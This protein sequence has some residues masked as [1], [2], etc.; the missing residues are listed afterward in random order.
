[1]PST[2]TVVKMADSG[3][4][5]LRQAITDANASNDP[6][7][8]IVFAIPGPGVHTI[9]PLSPLP[10]ITNSVTI[11][12]T[13]QPGYSGTPLIELDGTSAGANATGLVLDASNCTVRGLVINSFSRFGIDLHTSSNVI[14]GN[15]VGVDTTG[16]TLRAD[17]AGVVVQAA[18]NTIGG[19]SAGAGNVI[20]DGLDPS[21][22][23]AT[24]IQGNTIGLGADGTTVLGNHAYGIYVFQSRDVVIGGDTPAAR[25]VISGNSSFGIITDGGANGLVIQGNYIGTDR[26]GT[27]ARPNTYVGVATYSADVLIGGLTAT[28]GTGPGNVISGNGPGPNSGGGI[29]FSGNAP[30]TGDFVE[31]NIIGLGA[32]GTTALN[33]FQSGGVSSGMP[34]VTIGGTAA[35][36]R[37]VISG[38]GTGVGIVT[39]GNT[40]DVVEGNYIGTDVSGTQVAANQYGVV[41]AGGASG[42]TIGGATA[43]AGNL[44]SGNGVVG[45]QISD[46]GTSNNVVEGN[47]IGT[48]ADGTTPLGNGADGVRLEDGA[49]DN[50]IGLPGAGNVI[51]YNGGTGV[52]VLDD[53]SL[54]NSICG[55]SVFANGRLGIDLGGD[56]VT[57]NTPGG[58]HVGPNALQNFP[59]LYLSLAVPGG[60]AVAGTLN[61][62]PDATFTVDFYD[63]DAAD[64]SGYGQGQ[65][66]VGSI[67]V[68]TDGAGNGYYIVTVPGHVAEGTVLSATATDGQG[69]TSEFS[70]AVLVHSGTYQP[71]AG[72][73]TDPPPPVPIPEVFTLAGA[74]PAAPVIGSAALRRDGPGGQVASQAGDPRLDQLSQGTADRSFD[75]GVMSGEGTTRP[76]RPATSA[77]AGWDLADDV[78]LAQE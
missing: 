34:D 47:F 11:D 38:N 2:F 78:L 49:S 8:T 22:A 61:S 26:T 20:G 69:D 31:G 16:N 70:L 56:G 72:G 71:G 5:S 9:T 57:L 6:S 28:P 32:D 18:G 4:G 51:A 10:T 53:T 24:L 3:S 17:G 73:K 66:Y 65:R 63:S 74:Y 30:G 25:N 39:P 46:T 64:P 37:N 29:A 50:T 54:G 55:N 12:G 35:A 62:A 1:M 19:T 77:S 14:Q 45:V 48:A 7:N 44:I 21:Y 59:T 52:A 36:A 58:P 67:A 27:L 60:V 43:A 41:I 68:T 40:G 13:S 76:T 75:T 33:D 15:Y 23:D 42:S